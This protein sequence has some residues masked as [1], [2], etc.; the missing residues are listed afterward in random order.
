MPCSFGIA[1][2]DSF[3]KNGEEDN[4]RSEGKHKEGRHPEGQQGLIQDQQADKNGKTIDRSAEDDKGMKNSAVFDP[5]PHL[6][7]GEKHLKKKGQTSQ[8]ER[9]G[10]E[11]TGKRAKE[12]GNETGEK[13]DASS[14]QAGKEHEARP[15]HISEG[16]LTQGDHL[17]GENEEKQTIQSVFVI[18][19]DPNGDGEEQHSRHSHHD[20]RKKENKDVE[21]KIDGFEETRTFQN[22]TPLRR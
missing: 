11:H 9:E 7:R 12:P 15:P 18:G 3:E 2:V 10:D 5:C 19:K 21:R 13:S 14:S 17:K 8:T 6:V 20:P 4:G 22:L 16:S 1:G